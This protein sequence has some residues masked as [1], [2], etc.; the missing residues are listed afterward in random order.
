VT[1]VK[2]KKALGLHLAWVNG[3]ANGV[4]ADLSGVDLR[5][6]DLSGVDLSYA[7]LRHADLSGVD[8][9][10]A[11]LHH[12]DLSGVDLRHADLSGVD[13]S[14]ADL[15]H[16]DIRNANLNGAKLD[17]SCWPLW[18]GSLDV[19]VDAKIAAQLAYHFCQVKCDDPEVKQVQEAMQVLASKFHRFW[20]CGKFPE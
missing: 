10:H 19:V 20:E 5:H 12:A 17:F 16:A 2:I 15:R 1:A 9:R 11:N 18:C 14:Y 6:A 8:L 4:R 13:L 3:R 7:N